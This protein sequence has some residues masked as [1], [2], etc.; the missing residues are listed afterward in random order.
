MC[1]A[2]LYKIEVMGLCFGILFVTLQPKRA[3]WALITEEN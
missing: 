1:W 2:A 3:Y